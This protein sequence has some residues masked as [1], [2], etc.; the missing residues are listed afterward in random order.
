MNGSSEVLVDLANLIARGG[1]KIGDPGVT[2]S[3]G[4]PVVGAE[5]VGTDVGQAHR[6]SASR[7]HHTLMH[8]ANR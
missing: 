4:T 6:F 1:V 8:G 7:P 2:R 3:P 5:T